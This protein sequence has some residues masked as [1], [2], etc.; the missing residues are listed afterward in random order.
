MTKENK[1]RV[2]TWVT[3]WYEWVRREIGKNIAKDRMSDY[4]DDLT[5][6]MIES[7]YYLSD[8]KIEQMLRDDKIQW[9]ILRGA[10]M[11]LRSSSSPFWHIYRKHKMSARTNGIGGSHSNIFDGIWED[12]DPGLEKCFEGAWGELDWYLRT[13]ME[14][15]FYQRWSL[16]KLHKYYNISKTHLVK[17]L[18]KAINEIRN[19]CKDC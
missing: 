1:A 19:K 3:E 2:D 12:Y 11:Q 4:A 8:E 9:W 10:S 13:L 7:L 17:D 16:E 6:H 18:N 15:H 5:I 14:K